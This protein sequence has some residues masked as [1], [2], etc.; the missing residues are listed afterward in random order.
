MKRSSH[1]RL[2]VR[3]LPLFPHDTLFDKIARSVSLAGC[4]PRKELFEA[5]EV[6]RQTRRKF[7]GGRIVDLAC[8]HGLLAQMMLLL[9]HTSPGAI[10]VDKFLP[11]SCL[12]L[13][14]TLARS[15]PWLENRIDFIQNDL[16][17]VELTPQDIVVS[18]HACGSLSDAI[19]DRT[20]DAG[21]RLAIL[22]CCHDLKTCDSGGLQGWMD[23]PLAIDT[24]RV[25]RLKK[26]GYSVT[27]R[28]IP[29]DITPKNR[30]ILAE[31]S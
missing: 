23:G 6:A 25:E 31:P 22:P 15:W 13:H 2:T 16:N 21:A 11:P 30:L 17:A 29:V 3:S 28:T 18:A 26:N 20:I 8:G 14:T 10:A 4:L 19:I 27:T 1:N 24:T 9:D 7:R 5:W 12:K